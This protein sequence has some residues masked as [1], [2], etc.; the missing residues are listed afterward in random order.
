MNTPIH[1]A[2]YHSIRAVRT[3]EGNRLWID[4]TNNIF[5][6]VFNEGRLIQ[7]VQIP[8]VDASWLEYYDTIWNKVEH[9]HSPYSHWNF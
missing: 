7:Q 6:D 2:M 8:V 1:D 5:L 3:P 4:S 9:A